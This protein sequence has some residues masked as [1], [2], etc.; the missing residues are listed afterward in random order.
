MQ[1]VPPMMR[2][3]RGKPA[4][5]LLAASLACT[6][7]VG[8]NKQ[9]MIPNTKVADTSL[10]REILRVVEKYRRA[11]IKRDQVAILAL[12]HPS[13]NDHAGTPKADDDLDFTGVKKFLK[14]RYKNATKIRMRIEYLKVA[15]KGREARVDT[16][17]DATFVYNQP[18][19]SPYYRRLV[20]N[21]RF[22]LLKEGATWRFVSGL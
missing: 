10:N 13:Y 16:W 21:Q 8:C 1:Y 2:N 20:D 4:T 22:T 7:L 15:V 6:A 18:N 3:L 17:L 9:K 5:L 19:G 11:A 14:N 12:V